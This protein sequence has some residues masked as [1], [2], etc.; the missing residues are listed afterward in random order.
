MKKIPLGRSD[1]L[2]PEIG[3]GMM[4]IAEMSTE[5]AAAWITWCFEHGLNF[6]DHADIYGGGQ[7][8]AIFGKAWRQ[9]G[10]KR[11]QLIIQSKCGI[12]PG[13]M[14]DFSKDHILKSVNESLERLQTDY[15]DVLV[16][17]R[18]DALMEPEEV[19]EAFQI[20]Y[21]AGSVR[22]FGVSNFRPG[23]IELL[24]KHLP[25]PLLC[26]QMQ[27]SVANSWLIQQD[28]EANMPTE[29][30]P[31]RDGGLLAYCRL[32]DITIQ[33]WSPLQF[34]NWEGTFLNSPKY[35]KLNATLKEL[36]EKYEVAPA[37]I[38]IAWILRHPAH[39]QVIAGT[40]KPK[41]MEEMLKG[42]AIQLSREE[43]YRLYM[44]AGHILP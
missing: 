11:E 32:H 13:K 36:A 19:A 35:D 37:S 39:M 22:H 31:D 6:F 3:V 44:D 42:A 29:G 34:G 24:Q 23:Q 20:L 33:A 8:E 25:F 41:H 16:L 38:A 5:E 27:L 21:Q 12:V 2:V 43:W 10:L 40:T 4:R 14:Y 18:P 7:C 15:L 1:L 30:A 9:T 26:D 28:L 17:H